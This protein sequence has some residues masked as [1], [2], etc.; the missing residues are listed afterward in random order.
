MIRKRVVKI[1]PADH[2]R[3]MSLDDFEHA[4]G[5]EGYLY[6]LG[7]GEIVV[8]DVP[9]RLHLWQLIALRNALFF[10]QAANPGRIHSVLGGAECKLLLPTFQSKR[11]PDLT[12]YRTN[13]PD[14]PNDWIHWVPDIVVEVVSPGSHARDYEEKRDEY[15]QLGVREYWVVDG[16]VQEILVLQRSGV[17]WRERRLRPPRVLRTRLLPGFAVP[18]ASV[19]APAS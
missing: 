13:P 5:Q 19:F 12:V 18:V 14:D 3:R 11:H 17:Q 9:N 2:G 10:Y 15:L 7:R 16:D 4:E 1:G 8:S 6:E